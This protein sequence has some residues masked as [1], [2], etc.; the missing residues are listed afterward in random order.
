MSCCSV[1]AFECAVCGT[2]T[3]YESV[4]EPEAGCGSETFCSP[5][6]FAAF[7]THRSPEGER[8]E[9]SMEERP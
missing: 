6:C 7:R 9:T 1:P 4:F 3:P 2:W 8:G 5:E